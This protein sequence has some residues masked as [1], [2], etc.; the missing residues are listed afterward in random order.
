MITLGVEAYLSPSTT[1]FYIICKGS[2][3]CPL[4]FRSEG[5]WTCGEELDYFPPRFFI[6]TR[7]FSDGTVVIRWV[8]EGEST[9]DNKCNN[10]E[11]VYSLDPVKLH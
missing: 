8:F 1:F 5:L 2:R 7:L 9:F 6:N 11:N 4:Y 3:A 10:N